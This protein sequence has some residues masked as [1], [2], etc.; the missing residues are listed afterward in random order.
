MFITICYYIRK[1]MKYLCE[2]PDNY[3]ER[4]SVDY[5]ADVIIEYDEIDKIPNEWKSQTLYWNSDSESPYH[6]DITPQVKKNGVNYLNDIIS[7]VPENV[8]DLVYTIKYN[9]NNKSYKYTSR[10]LR[11]ITWPHK[12]SGM[13]FIQ[14]IMSAWALDEFGKEVKDI[15]KHIKKAS[16][17]RGDFHDQDVKI[18][19]IMKY[20]YKNIVIKYIM[21]QKTF[22]E[23]DSVL[24]IIN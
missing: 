15:T 8:K 9:Y 20:D 17:P 2:L 24:K 16:G 23:N 18:M 6:W 4:V 12:A 11:G 13:K 7:N 1:F 3:I 22:S 10:D 5:R 14:P 19:D 21:S